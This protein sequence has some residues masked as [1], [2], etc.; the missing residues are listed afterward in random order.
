MGDLPISGQPMMF[1]PDYTRSSTSVVIADVPSQVI[2][3]YNSTDNGS[4]WSSSL[5]MTT[6]GTPYNGGSYY[7]RVLPV[8]YSVTGATYVAIG[9]RY[10]GTSSSAGGAIL[11]SRSN[12]SNGTVTA[13][14]LNNATLNSHYTDT[15]N[16]GVNQLF[17]ATKQNPENSYLHSVKMAF[18]SLLVAQRIHPYTLQNLLIMVHHGPQKIWYQLIQHLLMLLVKSSILYSLHMTCQLKNYSSDGKI[19]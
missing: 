3:I 7:F 6:S 1:F 16:Y 2:R 15:S 18:V 8:F 10:G 5:T 17:G 19:N 14:S 11:Y 13:I 4:T 12:F 9:A